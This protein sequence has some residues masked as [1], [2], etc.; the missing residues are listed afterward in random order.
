MEDK[1][2]GSFII[3]TSDTIQMVN[4]YHLRPIVYRKYK[5]LLVKEI[6]EELISDIECDIDG[7][8]RFN[9]YLQSEE[10]IVENKRT[11][12]RLLNELKEGL[13]KSDASSKG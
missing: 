2:E 9:A 4:T 6:A 8:S 13:A 1:G 5:P 12:I 11:I 10:E 3:Q 7:W